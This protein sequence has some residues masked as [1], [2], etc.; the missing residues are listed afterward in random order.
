[1]T[2][3]AA[4]LTAWLLLIGLIPPAAAQPPTLFGRAVQ[5]DGLHFQVAFGWGGGTPGGGLFHNMELGGTFANGMT[6]AYNHVFIQLRGYSQAEGVP[7][8]IG[9]HLLQWKIPLL[10]RDLV[11]KLAVG[12]GGT[13]DQSDGISAHLGLAWSYGVDLHLPVWATSGLTLGLTGIHVVTDQDGAHAGWALSLGY[14]WF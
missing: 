12:P 14:T 11:L 2:R 1:M 4:A 8:L 10:Y 7:D 13:H 5:R 3:K 9:G 6:L